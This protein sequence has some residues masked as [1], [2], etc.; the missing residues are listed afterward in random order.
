[1]GISIDAQKNSRSEYAKSIHAMC[2]IIVERSFSAV[3]SID[4][5][6]YFTKNYRQELKA[7]N[8]LHKQTYDVINLKKEQLQKENVNRNETKLIDEFGVKKKQAFLDILLNATD[9]N[10][11]LLLSDVEIRQEVDTMLFAV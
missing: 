7:I 5:L 4:F 2:R 1:M 11:K 8:I 10:G 3:Q 6:Y 9:K